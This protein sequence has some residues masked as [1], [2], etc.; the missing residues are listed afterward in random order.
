MVRALRLDPRL[1]E[2]AVPDRAREPAQ[3]GR[4]EDGEIVDAG[5]GHHA[6]LFGSMSIDSTRHAANEKVTHSPS[7]QQCIK[8]RA[9]ARHR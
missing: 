2:H 4:D 5:E 7:R 6:H 9:E 8:R 1:A 3:N